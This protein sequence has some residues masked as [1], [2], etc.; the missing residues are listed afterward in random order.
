MSFSRANSLVLFR[1]LQH[2]QASLA[3]PLHLHKLRHHFD[4]G[5]HGHCNHFLQPQFG[6]H[7]TELSLGLKEEF[8][9]ILKI[10]SS[11]FNSLLRFLNTKRNII[12]LLNRLET[13]FGILLPFPLRFSNPSEIGNRHVLNSERDRGGGVVG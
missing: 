4:L 1:L 3:I 10:L 2:L 8:V 11:F 7:S 13:T 5:L 6:R 9:S 12:E